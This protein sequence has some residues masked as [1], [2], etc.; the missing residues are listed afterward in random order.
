MVKIQNFFGRRMP[1]QSTVPGYLERDIVDMSAIFHTGLGEADG[2]RQ[3]EAPGGHGE[4]VGE[5]RGASSGHGEAVDERPITRVWHGKTRVEDADRY[6][7]YLQSTGIHD[8][9]HTPG[10][11]EV[12]IGRSIEADAAHFWTIS[13]WKDLDSIRAFAGEPVEKARYYPEDKDF[14]LCFEPTVVHYETYPVDI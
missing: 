7:E 9:L 2:A 13:V 8:Y 4:A 6:L 11:R 3:R 1:P 14:L 12:R 5:H 10:I